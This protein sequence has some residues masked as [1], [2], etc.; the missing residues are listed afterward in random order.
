LLKPRNRE[1]EDVFRAALAPKQF[2]LGAAFRINDRPGVVS[3]LLDQL[4]ELPRE[5]QWSVAG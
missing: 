5:D 1:E 4:P 3:L 2:V